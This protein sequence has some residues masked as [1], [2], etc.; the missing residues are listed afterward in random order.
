[1]K[2]MD[3]LGKQFRAA[4]D[5][6]FRSRCAAFEPKSRNSIR[7]DNLLQRAACQDGRRA[8]HE[9]AVRRCCKHPRCTMFQA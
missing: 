3:R 8:A 4:D 2:P 9:Q 6:D 7:H 1:M 5:S